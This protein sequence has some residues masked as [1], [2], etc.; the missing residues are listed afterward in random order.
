[1]RKHLRISDCL[2][3][4]VFLLNSFFISRATPTQHAQRERTEPPNKQGQHQ[5]EHQGRDGVRRTGR[6]VLPAAAHHTHATAAAA[7]PPTRE[8]RGGRAV[9]RDAVA[10]WMGRDRQPLLAP[11]Q[12]PRRGERARRQRGH[13]EEHLV[14]GAAQEAGPR[15]EKGEQAR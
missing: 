3:S 5:R 4:L 15:A 11:G 6:L 14:P 8:R 10:S 7:A 2:Y 9:A 13:R 12:A 1:M